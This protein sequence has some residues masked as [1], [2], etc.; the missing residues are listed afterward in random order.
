MSAFSFV[1][2]NEVIV[3][4]FTVQVD[5]NLHHAKDSTLTYS[6]EKRCC[7]GSTVTAASL[8]MII[9]EGCIMT[10]LCAVCLLHRVLYM[11]MAT[12]LSYFFI[13]GCITSILYLC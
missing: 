7:Y 5:I 13:I 11:N 9:L 1:Q 10:A 8:I 4:L 3:G 6:G 2:I 12:E